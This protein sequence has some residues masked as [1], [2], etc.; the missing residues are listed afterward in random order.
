MIKSGENHGL[1]LDPLCRRE[2]SSMLFT[3]CAHLEP[4]PLFAMTG[5]AG[6]LPV[7][8][9]LVSIHDVRNP[10]LQWLRE[11]SASGWGLFFSSSYAWADLCSYLRS[12]LLVRE[13]RGEDVRELVFRFWDN[14]IFMRIAKNL[15]Q[16]CTRLMGPLHT[17]I[18]QDE[19]GAWFRVENP[20]PPTQTKSR[21]SP[22]YDFDEAHA[23]LFADKTADVLAYNIAESL[24]PF[25]ESEGLPLP[26]SERL[27]D[28]ARRQV[29]AAQPL[30]LTGLEE[31][32]SY[33]VCALYLGEEATL[34]QASAI[35]DGRAELLQTLWRRCAEE[36]HKKEA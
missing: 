30:G 22:W 16:A 8:P 20:S 34:R 3:H 18:A 23:E 6:S 26:P 35:K 5:L 17:V 29:E 21:T 25:V 12:L 10:L 31:L 11:G 24:Y 28:F 36:F 27:L 9:W 7:S 15:P 2:A 4:V 32:T 13:S 33:V 1:L 14:R 19:H